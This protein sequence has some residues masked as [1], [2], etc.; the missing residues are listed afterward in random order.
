MKQRAFIFCLAIALIDCG[1]SGE[2]TMPSEEAMPSDVAESFMD[3]QPIEVL[4]EEGGLP[5]VP[6][7]YFGEEVSTSG[8][9]IISEGVNYVI[10]TADQL[11]QAAKEYATYRES[12]GFRTQVVLASELASGKL[13]PYWL[14]PSLRDLLSKLKKALPPN[15]LLYLLILGDAPDKYEDSCTCIP[16][17]PCTN[18]FSMHPG[19]CQTDNTY[20]DLDEDGIPDVAVGRIPARSLEEVRTYLQ[21]VKAYEGSY[22]TG[23]FNRRVAVY[24]GQANFGEQIDTMLEVAVME[25]LKR[26][27]HAFDIIGAYASPYSPYYYL[28]FEDKVIDLFNDG[29]LM[30]VYVGH[31]LSDWTEGLTSEQVARIHCTKRLPFVFLF[32]CY[33]GNYVGLDRSVAEELIHKSDGPITALGSTDISHPYGNA[34]LVYEVQRAVLDAMPKTIGEAILLAKLWSIENEDE[35]RAMIDSVAATQPDLDAVRQIRIRLQ[36]LDLYNLLGDPALPMQYPDSWAS[37]TSG[38]PEMNPTGTLHITGSAPGISSGQAFITLEVERDVILEQLTPINP[39]NPDPAIV[40]ANWKKAVNKVLVSKTVPVSNNTFSAEIECPDF[41][42]GGPY[43]LKV[44]ADDGTN[45]SFG[46]STI[47]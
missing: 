37:F 1:T 33:A 15:D 17:V 18:D 41:M 16:S 23:L 31:G 30:V 12:K 2:E 25:G 13:T 24:T 29:S 39:E 45:D 38:V 20:G 5:D 14:V 34:V 43:Y 47:K 22:K 11:L 21:K 26:V 7:D 32:A 42:P 8:D 10:L 19:D 27:S 40:Q 9:V 4:E 46:F 3:S 35:F 6:A 36:H 44:Y 28:P